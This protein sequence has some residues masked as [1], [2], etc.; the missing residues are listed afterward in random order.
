MARSRRGTWALV[1]AAAMLL[2]SLA[3]ACS[4]PTQR[5]EGGTPVAPSGD[6]GGPPGPVNVPDVADDGAYP[7]DAAES[8][9]TE[10]NPYP[11]PDESE[12]DEGSAEEGAGEDEAAEGET[13]AEGTETPEG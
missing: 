2:L 11:E 9:P 3:A 12:A 5:P 1:A 10:R 7:G 6:F 13:A 8:M 4:S